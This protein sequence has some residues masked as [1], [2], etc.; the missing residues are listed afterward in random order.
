MKKLLLSALLLA[1]TAALAANLTDYTPDGTTPSVS[2]L[3]KFSTTG[4][5]TVNSAVTDDGTNLTLGRPI[6][7]QLNATPGRSDGTNDVTLVATD[8]GHVVILTNGGGAVAVHVPTLPAGCAVGLLR[9]GTSTVTPSASGTTQTS[10]VGTGAR[11]Q[12]SM[13]SVYFTDATNYT[14]LGDGA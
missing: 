5:A 9:M 2:A 6:S 1:S 11:A 7:A 8:C 3:P 10:A 4:G 13:I 14:I 12:Y